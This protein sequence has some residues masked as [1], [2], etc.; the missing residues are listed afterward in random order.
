MEIDIYLTEMKVK[1]IIWC[2]YK[3]NNKWKTE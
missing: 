2:N 3:F 1:Y